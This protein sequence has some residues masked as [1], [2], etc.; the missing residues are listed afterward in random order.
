MLQVVKPPAGPKGLPLLGNVFDVRGKDLLGYWRETHARYGETV[1]LRLGPLDCW[2]FAGPEG[3]YDVLVTQHKSIRKG[4]GYNGLRL[5]LGEGLISTDAP[6]W[7]S[8]RQSLNPLFS[9]VAIE[10]YAG[11]VY[12]AV[13]LGLDDLDGPATRAE[14][15]DIG[16]AM[17]RVTMRVVSQAA[18]GVDFGESHAGVADA[19]N[20]AFAFIAD[21]SADPVHPPLF[22]PTARNR[23]Y[24]RNLEVID[25]FVAG[26]VEGARQNPEQ[27]GLNGQILAALKHAPPKLLRDEIVSLYFAGFETTARGMAYAMYLLARHP[28]WLEP[29]AHEAARFQRP[30]GGLA[31]LKGLPVAAEIVSETLRLYPPVPIMGRQTLADT[32]IGGYPVKGGSL[33]LIVPFIAQRD[34]RFWPAGDDFAPDPANPLS[35]RLPHKGAWMP[36]GGGPR[37]CLGKHFALVEMAMATALLAQRYSWT[38]QSDAPLELEFHGTIRPKTP[39][40]ARL[41][42]RG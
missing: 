23:A 29:L 21:I 1:K 9:P 37:L 26:L 36:F 31:V 5:L 8:E 41:A 40:L 17:T 28:E 42:R 13:K 4:F 24:K 38:L 27:G 14:V 32:V 3:I 34:P 25:A 2:S 33:V 10:G 15:I 39:L 19:F 11:A 6:H 35:R 18:F 16:A 20:D 22:V 7:A 30:D 12:D